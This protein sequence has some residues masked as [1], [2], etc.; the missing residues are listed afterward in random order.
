MATPVIK[1][2]FLEGRKLNSYH[3]IYYYTY[4]FLTLFDEFFCFLFFVVFLSL[5]LPNLI[6]LFIKSANL[7]S[8]L[9]HLKTLSYSFYME[10]YSVQYYDTYL[11]KL[12]LLFSL[13]FASSSQRRNFGRQTKTLLVVRNILIKRCQEVIMDL[14]SDLMMLKLVLLLP[15]IPVL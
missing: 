10:H 15:N 1:E 14:I 9:F 6:F 11:F 2:S 5:L 3:F 13:L 4:Y 7:V 8:K 12:H